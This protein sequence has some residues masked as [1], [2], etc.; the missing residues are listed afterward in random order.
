MRM[1]AK[2]LF[3]LALAAVFALLSSVACQQTT[4]PNNQPAMN[5]SDSK[6]WDTYVNEFLEAYFVA[7]PD[8]AVRQGRHEFDGKLPDWSAEGFAKEVKRLHAERDRLAGFPDS[9]LSQR[10]RFER[11]YIASQIDADLFWMES[12]EWPFRSPQFYAD[13]IDPDVYGSREYAPLDQRRKADTAYAK[14]MPTELEQIRKNVRTPMPKTCGNIGH[15]TYGG[16]IAVYEKEVTAI[17]AAVK[18]DQLD[19]RK[20]TARHQGDEG[21]ERLV[22]NAEPTAQQLRGAKN[23][24]KC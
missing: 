2:L 16:L 5:T 13:G 20:L 22:Q 12:A 23:L 9:T 4:S 11:E 24:V 15:T 7:R 3:R 14:A 17:V 19:F 6:E 21:N 1:P 18:D 8:F 10:Q